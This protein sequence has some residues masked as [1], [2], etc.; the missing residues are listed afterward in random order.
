MALAAPGV[1]LR[2]SPVTTR[3]TSSKLGFRSLLQEFIVHCSLSIVHCPFSIVH[4]PLSCALRHFAPQIYL[5][6][7]YGASFRALKI[8]K[9][10][11]SRIV[12]NS[13]EYISLVEREIL[14]LKTDE[15]YPD[16]F[17]VKNAKSM[18]QT[19]FPSERNYFMLR[20]L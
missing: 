14:R 11:F 10:V 2:S 12:L 17:G 18:K 19:R 9:N 16:L 7:E 20:A 4:C 8:L 1:E 15:K 13:K 3:E 6:P 5:F